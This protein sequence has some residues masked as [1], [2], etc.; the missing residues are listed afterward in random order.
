MGVQEFTCLC[1]VVFAIEWLYFMTGLE[2]W[3]C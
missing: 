2:K 3:M 1:L